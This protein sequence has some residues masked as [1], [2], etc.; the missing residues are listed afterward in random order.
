MLRNGLITY[1]TIFLAELLDKT[2]LATVGRS[3]RFDDPVAVAIAAAL[4]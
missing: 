1:F 3:V 4:H 2:T